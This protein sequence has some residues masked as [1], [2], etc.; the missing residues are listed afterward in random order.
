[1]KFGC[2]YCHT[3]C[4]RDE[5]SAGNII[6]CPNCGRDF[7]IRT[8]PTVSDPVPRSARSNPSTK[9]KIW[10]RIVLVVV[11]LLVWRIVASLNNDRYRH[12]QTIAQIDKDKS[13]NT[14]L[15]AIVTGVLTLIGTCVWASANAGD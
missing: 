4:E 14:G 3:F 5:S 6:T 12:E 13:D 15:V 1:M 7:Q 8:L 2:P 9:S 11:I 10:S